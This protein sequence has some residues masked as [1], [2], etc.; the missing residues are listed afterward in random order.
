[1]VIVSGGLSKG[2]ADF[3]RQALI[4]NHGILSVNSVL[5]RPGKPA[6]IGRIAEALFIGLPGNP[7]A[8]AVVLNQIGLPALR[9][10]AGM[11]SWRAVGQQAEASFALTKPLGRTEFFPVKSV[12]ENHIGLP[13]VANLGRGSSGSL[14]PMAHADGIAVLAEKTTLVQ[15]GDL[16]RFYPL[17]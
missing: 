16:V 15:K 12:G 6:A 10:R 14:L 11:H 1:V 8:A 13:I 2:G 17:V 9:A 4:A 7:M 3:T 5:M